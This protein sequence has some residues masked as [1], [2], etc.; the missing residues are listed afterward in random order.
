MKKMQFFVFLYKNLLGKLLRSGRMDEKKTF[1][2][3][4]F[5]F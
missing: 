1:L 5:A 3:F 4:V 2:L